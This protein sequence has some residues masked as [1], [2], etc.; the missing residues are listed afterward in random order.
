MLWFILGNVVGDLFG[1]FLMCLVQI[2]HNRRDDW[3]K[4]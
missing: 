2:S 1:I 4:Q 3:D